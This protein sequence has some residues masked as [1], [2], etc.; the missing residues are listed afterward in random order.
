MQPISKFVIVGG[1]TSGWLAAAILTHFLKRDLCRVELI[2]S[3]ELGTIGIGES[4][5]PPLVGLLQR[6]GIDEHEFIR[7]TEATYK[8]GIQFVDWYRRGE[9]YFH[10]FG[11]IGR[12]IGSNEFYQCWLKAREQGDTAPLQAYS[13]SC[14]MAEQGRFFPPDRLP[15]TPIGGANYAYHVDA[16]LLARFLRRFAEARGLQRIEGKVTSVERRED[17]FIDHLMLEDGRRIDGDFFIDCTGF[18]GLLIEQALG[19]EWID[20]SAQ[21]PCDRAIAVKTEHG[22]R[23]H[24]YTRATAEAAGWIWRIP[25][26]GRVGQGYVYSSQFCSDAVAKGVLMRRLSGAL[27]DEPKLIRFRTGHR[28]EIWKR[29]CLALGLAAGFIEPLEATAIHLIA[30]GLDFFLRYFPDRSCDEALVREYNR[31]MHADFAEIRDFVQLHYWASARDDSP[32]WEACTNLP[33]SDSLRERIELFKAQGIV[34]EGM[35]EL[36][37]AT[38][39][40]SVFEG[41]GIRPKRY[42]PRVDNLDYAQIKATLETARAA[43]QGMVSHLPSHEEFLATHAGPASSKSEEVPSRGAA[44]RVR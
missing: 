34:R 33:I 18:K 4:T 22:E 42:S 19:S 26:R 7:E 21:L 11:V 8:L 25:L 27:T 38:S 15:G 29:N 23:I 40:L 9:R 6:L 35:D 32:F 41:M 28:R 31:R 10:P 2:E 43:I 13:P 30:R 12:P 39:W 5:V 37:R 24:P 20:W 16:A 14:V 1:G 44:R 17:G 3:E 36:F